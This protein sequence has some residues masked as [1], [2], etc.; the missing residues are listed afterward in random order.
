MNTTIDL[1]SISPLQEHRILFFD[2]YYPQKRWLEVRRLLM[3]P[4]EIYA[5][6][7]N[8]PPYS[9]CIGPDENPERTHVQLQ[10]KLY[11]QGP[12]DKDEEVDSHLVV[13]YDYDNACCILHPK[14]IIISA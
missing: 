12:L 4:P 11:L 1:F 9:I 7:K 6:V 13:T 10:F 5:I 14:Q 8:S 2:V 3:K